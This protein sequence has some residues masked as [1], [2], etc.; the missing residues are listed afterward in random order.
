MRACINSLSQFHSQMFDLATDSISTTARDSRWING[1]TAAINASQFDRIRKILQES[2]Q[3]I[4]EVTD[5]SGSGDE[6]YHI[7]LLAFP[8][9]QNGGR[10]DG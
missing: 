7:G 8:V 10:E 4:E 1:H 9:T 6:V 5:K 2:L 3:K